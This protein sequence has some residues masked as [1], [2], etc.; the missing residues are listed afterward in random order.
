MFNRMDNLE[1]VTLTNLGIDVGFI[2][3]PSFHK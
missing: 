2:H 3:S 1:E